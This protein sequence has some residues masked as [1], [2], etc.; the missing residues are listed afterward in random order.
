MPRK[1]PLV[2][3]QTVAVSR[4][5]YMPR[6][7]LEYVDEGTTEIFKSPEFDIGSLA[8][9]DQPTGTGKTIVSMLGAVMFCAMRGGDVAE[10][11]R[12]QQECLMRSSR[13]SVLKQVT[14]DTWPQAGAGR[15]CVVFVAGHLVQ[16]WI[17]QA[18]IVKEIIREVH[19]L[20]EWK[21]TV[22]KGSKNDHADVLRKTRFACTSAASKH[23][24]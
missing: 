13:T 1:F 3:I 23:Q 24:Q 11:L 9:L 8:I 21:V 6:R 19:R 16:Q 18:N 5:V 4:L 2:Y 12:L 17:D 10:T 22:T 7:R 20:D 14:L 15:R